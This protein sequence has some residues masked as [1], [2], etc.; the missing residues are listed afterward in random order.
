MGFLVEHPLL[1]LELGFRLHFDVGQPYGF[2]IERAMPTARWLREK[3]RA[4]QQPV[5][6]ALLVEM[7][8]ALREETL[9][10]G[11]IVP[12][13]V[14]HIYCL[15]QRKQLA[16]LCRTSASKKT[17]NP[18]AIPIAGCRSSWRHCRRSRQPAWSSH[19]FP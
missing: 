12:F 9:G 7:V 17:S 16:R 14:T 19:L 2:D 10:L 6:Q 3:Q 4:L 11:E 1:V 8:Q 13:D 5:L 15:G 18:K